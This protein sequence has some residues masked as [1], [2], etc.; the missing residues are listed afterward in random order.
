[1]SFDSA[2]L[3]SLATATKQEYWLCSDLS[4]KKSTAIGRFFWTLIAKRFDFL[5]KFFYGVDLV[6]SHSQ[7]HK[8]KA[9]LIAEKDPKKIA[10]YNS[11]VRAFNKISKR[12]NAPE[13]EES[14]LAPGQDNPTTSTL[15][16]QEQF[17]QEKIQQLT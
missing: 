17:R 9:K 15:K 13:I 8:I 3:E 6:Q 5:R 7:F 4:V 2:K 10:V 11:A 14:D 12:R 16:L 1:M